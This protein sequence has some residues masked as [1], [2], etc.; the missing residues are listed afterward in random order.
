MDDAR[1]RI[2]V[3]IAKRFIELLRQLEPKWKK[4]YLRFRFD[5]GQYG[6]NASYENDSKVLLIDAMKNNQFY[7]SVN[8]KGA[9]LMKDLGNPQGVFLLVVDSTFK[10]KY[11]FEYEDLERWKISKMDGATGV[12]VGIPGQCDQLESSAPP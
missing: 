6:S 8:K 4:G 1:T 10:Y 7:V 12:P 9:E 3:D 5:P 2:I 11:H